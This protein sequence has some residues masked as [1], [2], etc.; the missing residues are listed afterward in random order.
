M[1]SRLFL[2]TASFAASCLSFFVSPR[3]LSPPCPVV[4]SSSAPALQASREPQRELREASTMLRRL[5]ERSGT[6]T[7]FAAGK[8]ILKVAGVVNNPPVNASTAAGN[9]AQ[10]KP[11]TN[12]LGA[13]GA[14]LVMLQ[15]K[16][17]KADGLESWHH[18]RSLLQVTDSGKGPF[19][20]R[21]STW[22]K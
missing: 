10:K 8:A 6:A 9:T 21:L 2:S 20:K 5:L 22:P 4:P 15:N 11:H 16:V 18:Q 7:V 13:N 19:E 17:K 12:A 1:L 14:A 3:S